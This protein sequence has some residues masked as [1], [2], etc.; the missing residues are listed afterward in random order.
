M[1][2]VNLVTTCKGRL[3]QLKR[4]LPT[5]LAQHTELEY[6]VTV[7]DYDCPDM[8]AAWLSLQN[9]PRVK[10]VKLF[11]KPK[12]HLSHARNVGAVSQKA[13]VVGFVDADVLLS[14]D[15]MDKAV[16]PIVEGTADALRPEWG[17]TGCGI[18]AVSFPAFDAVR[19]FGEDLEGWGWEDQ[20]LFLRLVTAGYRVSYYPGTLIHVQQH[21]N[22]MRLAHYSNKSTRG[23]L[24][25]SNAVNEHRAK[26]RCGLPNPAGYGRY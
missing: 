21:S 5:W 10:C 14:P 18:C 1:L 3:S 20:D 8:T 7:V 17:R 12:F 26:H 25:V 23:G 15:W 9:F 22:D 6:Q 4:S 24:P 11:D 13:S 16:R 2:A 19:G